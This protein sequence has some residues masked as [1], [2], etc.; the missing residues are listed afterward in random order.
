MAFLDLVSWVSG[1]ILPGETNDYEITDRA[2]D[3]ADRAEGEYIT[4]E[5]LAKPDGRTSEPLVAYLEEDE[6]PQYV[7][8]G[9]ELMISDSDSSVVRKHPAQ[10]LVISISDERVLYVVGGR[11]S[12]ELFEV[13]LTNIT[14]AYLDEDGLSRYLIVEADR[15]GDVMTFFADVTSE[16]N[17]DALG[18]SLEYAR[19]QS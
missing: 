3:L 8:L 4:P 19:L 12:D 10:Q 14:M 7:F 15:D 1:A 18:A 2:R 17:D 13:P 6:H 11:F 16:S 5:L 9:G